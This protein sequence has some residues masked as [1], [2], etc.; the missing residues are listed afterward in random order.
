ALGKMFLDQMDVYRAYWRDDPE[1]DTTNTRA[2]VPDLPAPPLDD[3]VIRRLC[4]F[5]IDNR[6]RWPPPGRRQP[7]AT[8]RSLLE[9]MLGEAEW[10]PPRGRNVVG[11]AATGA[12]GGQWTIALEG[13]QPVSLHVGLPG[14]EAPLVSLAAATLAELVAGRT[15]LDALRSRGCLAVEGDAAGRTA[16][17]DA[18]GS[19]APARRGLVTA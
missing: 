7:E 2:A 14:G 19:L 1:F 18:L 11:L 5:A 16:A 17:L 4:R 8:G 13:G 10:T 6:F 15:T 3:D 9:A 12:G